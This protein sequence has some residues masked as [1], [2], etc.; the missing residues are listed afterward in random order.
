MTLGMIIRRMIVLTASSLLLPLFAWVLPKTLFSPETDI[1]GFIVAIIPNL[2]YVFPILAA[3][4][5]PLMIAANGIMFR[6]PYMKISFA[7][8]ALLGAATPLVTIFTCGT[9]VIGILHVLLVIIVNSEPFYIAEE[10]WENI[11]EEF[12]YT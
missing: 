3:I 11:K 12:K 10:I 5:L 1:W 8:L 6:E 9:I 7:A 4:N 2:W